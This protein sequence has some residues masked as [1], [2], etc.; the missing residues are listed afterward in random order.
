MKEYRLY[1]FKAGR[2][3]WPH[4][5]YAADDASAVA[6]AEQR[7]RDG[8]QMELWQNGRKV[9]SWGFA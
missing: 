2:L 5:F 8:V 6:E 7:L 1:V 3:L 9:R 4:E